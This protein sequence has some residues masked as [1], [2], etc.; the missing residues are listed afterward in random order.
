MAL[1]D[2]PPHACTLSRPTASRDGGGGTALTYATLQA[3]VPCSID[4]AS[5]SERELFA[6]QGMVVTHTV[7][8]LTSKLTTAPARG[9]K[10]ADPDGNSYHVHGIS[11]GRAYG[12]IPAFTYLHCEEQL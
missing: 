10:A 2:N 12:G 4:T 7:G 3:S 8:I 11:R 9:D 6:Q 1:H 5:A